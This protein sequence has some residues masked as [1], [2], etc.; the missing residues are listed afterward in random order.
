MFDFFTPQQANEM[1]AEI[2]L[3]FNK[4]LMKRKEISTIEND[5][6]TIVNADASLELFFQKKKELNK[7]ILSFYKEIE[8]IEELG[9]LI[10]SLDEGL[11][12]FPSKRFGT[13]VWLC[14]KVGEAKIKF[15]HGKNEGFNGRKPLSIKGNYNYDNIED[16]R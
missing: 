10:K 11:V 12:D 2:N 13:E 6:D 9:V 3:R 16:F 5:L 8:E 7:A 4:I 1:L 15:W 14:W